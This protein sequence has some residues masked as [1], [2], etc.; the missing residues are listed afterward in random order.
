MART[1]LEFWGDETK[2]GNSPTEVERVVKNVAPVL[3]AYRDQFRPFEGTPEIAPG[4]ETVALYGHSPAQTG[5]V[6]AT[7]GQKLL[8]WAD[9]VHLSA[10]QLPEPDWYI[11]YDV[12]PVAAVATRKRVLQQVVAERIRIAGA[13]LPD[14]GIG[15]I[16]PAGSG[17]VFQPSR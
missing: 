14:H 3:K 6:L 15:F 2:I 17:F 5:F 4:I 11:I 9:T 16:E 8:F 12:D 10:F 1:E 7:G 13:H